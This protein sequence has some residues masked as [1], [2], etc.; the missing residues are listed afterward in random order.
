[1]YYNKYIVRNI[2]RKEKEMNNTVEIT[3]H[4]QNGKHYCQDCKP[5]GTSHKG[6]LVIS[7]YDHFC[8]GCGEDFKELAIEAE[9]Q[10]QAAWDAHQM[11]Y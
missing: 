5:H 10:E 9:R 11:G 4:E 6:T 7:D 3:I 2:K 8:A 1:M